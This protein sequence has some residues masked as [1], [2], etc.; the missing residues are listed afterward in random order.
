ML[1][2]FAN[3]VNSLLRYPFSEIWSTTPLIAS[4]RIEKAVSVTE[5]ILLDT[6]LILSTISIIFS[7]ILKN[8]LS[9]T[10]MS[11]PEMVSKPSS[12]VPLFSKKEYSFFKVSIAFL[13]RSERLNDLKN[14][15]TLFV[16]SATF[17]P[18]GVTF[19]TNLSKKLFKAV[20][21]LMES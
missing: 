12:A 4:L 14:S 19:S 5:I 18:T 7:A 13:T 15:M 17:S 2:P 6:D 3:L 8:P 21:S 20:P 9:E 1:S 10:D 16:P 11:A